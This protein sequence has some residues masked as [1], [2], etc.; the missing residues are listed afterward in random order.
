MAV[1]VPGRVLPLPLQGVKQEKAMNPALFIFAWYDAAHQEFAP[2][3]S[4]RKFYLLAL[5][6]PRDSEG[7][8]R[9]APLNQHGHQPPLKHRA[10]LLGRST[11]PSRSLRVWR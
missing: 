1:T 7:K 2:I 4:P 3:T 11:V 6:A 10:F 9:K 5:P 8:R